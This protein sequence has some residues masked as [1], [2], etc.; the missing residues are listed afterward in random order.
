MINNKHCYSKIF[1]LDE[2]AAKRAYLYDSKYEFKQRKCY[3]SFG[4]YQTERWVGDIAV[5]LRKLNRFPIKCKK[6]HLRQPQL[7]Y[8]TVNLRQYFFPFRGG[9]LEGFRKFEFKPYIL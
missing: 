1:V 3:F 9:F 8:Q 7:F 5:Q 6:N 4:I 2:R